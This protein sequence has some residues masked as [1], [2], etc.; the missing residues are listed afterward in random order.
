M[1]KARRELSSSLINKYSEE[2]GSNL[3]TLLF[4]GNYPDKIMVFLP[5]FN[6]PDLRN[7]YQKWLNHGIGLYV[8]VISGKDSINAVSLKTLDSLRQGPLRT[9]EPAEKAEIAEP[10]FDYILVPGLAFD[11]RGRRMGFGKG[12]YD[13]FLPGAGGKKIGI[14][15]D[16]QLWNEIPHDKHDHPVDAVI[17]DKEILEINI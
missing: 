6:E 7:H 13:R 1:K 8:P 15:Y 5:I 16:F 11:R 10:R 12:Y 9:L 17:S 3:E 2:I 14:A 4:S